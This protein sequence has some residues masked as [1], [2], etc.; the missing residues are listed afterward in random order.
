MKMLAKMPNKAA[1][2]TAA[3]KT[4]KYPR[5][6]QNPYRR[7]SFYSLAFDILAAHPD[8]LRRDTLVRLYCKESGKD[9]KRAMWDVSI[10]SSPNQDGTGHSSSQRFYYWVQKGAGGFLRLQIDDKRIIT[11]PNGAA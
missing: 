10:V 3:R 5:H 6:P 4:S 2:K 7:C 9:M 8:G 11:Q 1:D